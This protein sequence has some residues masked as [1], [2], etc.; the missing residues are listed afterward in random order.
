M[1]HCAPKQLSACLPTIVPRLGDVLADPHPKVTAAARTAL[2]EVGSVIRNPEVARLVP[3][4]LAAV[5]DPTRSN[6]ACLETLL[7]T[8]FVNTVD[9]AS[10]VSAAPNGADCGSWFAQR[11]AD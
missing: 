3:A 4:L 2:H 1:A 8:V 9:A 7:N 11:C 5:A 10:L 6:K